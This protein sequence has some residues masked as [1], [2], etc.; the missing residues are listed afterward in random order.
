MIP[1]SDKLSLLQF[2]VDVHPNPMV[3]ICVLVFLYDQHVHC[4]A[5][6]KIHS[7]QILNSLLTTIRQIRLTCL[8]IEFD[9]VVQ[10]TVFGVL[11]DY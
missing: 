7:Y 8:T 2:V 3:K 9:L 5:S 6:L 1:A 11:V 4:L 10:R